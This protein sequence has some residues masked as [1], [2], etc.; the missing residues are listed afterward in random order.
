MTVRSQSDR[1]ED[2]GSSVVATPAASMTSRATNWQRFLTVLSAFAPLMG[3]VTGAVGTFFV[4]RPNLAPSTS[5]E[6][7]IT[8]VAIEPGV[9]LAEYARHPT[10]GRVLGVRTGEFLELNKAN[11][12]TVGTVVH[13]DFKVVGYNSREVATRWTLFDTESGERIGESDHLEPLP[14]KVKSF[15]KKDTDIGSWET[16]VHSKAAAGRL[17]FVR[18]EL[19]D[20]AIGLRLVFRDTSSFMMH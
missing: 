8:N 14:F 15:E 11:I 20:A 2:H 3:V 12:D 6:A 5:N 19:F 13:F 4:L 9:T 17:V 10:V 16:W 7:N 18:L 1:E